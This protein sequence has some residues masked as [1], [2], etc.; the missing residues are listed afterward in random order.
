MG[1]I[2]WMAARQSVVTEFRALA[3]QIERVGAAR[4]GSVTEERSSSVR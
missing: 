3:E 2:E 4:A 1:R